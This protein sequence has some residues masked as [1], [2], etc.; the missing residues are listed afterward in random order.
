M[1]QPHLYC[2]QIFINLDEWG[3]LYETL[4]PNTFIFLKVVFSTKKEFSQNS[5]I[6]IFILK[7]F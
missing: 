7:R 2:A 6:H 1:R 3:L 5:Q 4:L